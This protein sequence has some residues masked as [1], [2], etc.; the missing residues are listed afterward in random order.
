MTEKKMSK[1]EIVEGFNQLRQEQR[2]I[3]AKVAELDADKAE[4]RAVIDALSEV[5]GNR[6]CYRLIGDVLVE[7]TVGDVLPALTKNREQISMLTED[8]NKQ[9]AEKG[10]E[11]NDF[12]Q[13]HN[14][15]VRGENP[16]ESAAAKVEAPPKP[17]QSTGVLVSKTD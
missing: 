14:I 12:R 10:K 9:L 11:L 1:E 15:T 8:L 4:H 5:S 16:N 3:A 2:R 13:K 17:G 6:K 7:R